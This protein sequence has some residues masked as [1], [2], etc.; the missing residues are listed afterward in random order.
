MAD[1]S[2][3]ADIRGINI[4]KLAKGFGDIDNIFKKF[5]NVSKTNAREIRWYQKTSGFLDTATT[6]G[7][8]GTLISN[9]SEGSLPFVTEQSWTRQ[10]SYVK[11]FFVQSPL[12]TMEDIKDSDIDVLGTNVR[13]LTR[14]VDR[15]VD[16]R[17]FSVI[18]EAAAATPTTPNPTTT[19]TSVATADGW[20]D[21]ETGNPI[22]DILLMKQTLYSQGY[23]PEGAVLAMNSI[24]HRYLLNFLISTKGSSIPNYSSEKMNS[25]VVMN[26]LGVNVV[27]SENWTTDC[28]GMFIP[29]RSVSYKSFMPKSAVVMDNPG[30]GKTIRVWE[31][32]EFM[33]T[34]P[35]SVYILTA[36]SA[37]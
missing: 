15:K 29:G 2:G 21:A 3:E 14:A 20:D 13:D 6:T 12:F 19:N 7:V 23:N 22:A 11:K 37:A 35:K 36:T 8:T 28:V 17:F 30:I 5:A 1:T 31:E 4:D 33:L 25:G 26:I 34:D 9:T 18:T 16:L 10:T 32:G 24:E 27:V